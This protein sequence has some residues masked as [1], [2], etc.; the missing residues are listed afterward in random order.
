MEQWP[1]ESSERG[2]SMVGWRGSARTHLGLEGWMRE[3]GKDGGYFGEKQPKEKSRGLEWTEC[4]E[5]AVIEQDRLVQ[6]S[7]E[8]NYAQPWMPDIFFS[9]NN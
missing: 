5:E 4:S 9:L 1:S 8:S 3:E 7:L 2:E 6:R